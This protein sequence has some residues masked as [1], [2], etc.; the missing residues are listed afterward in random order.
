MKRR[1]EGVV[2]WIGMVL[3]IVGVVVMG[4]VIGMMGKGEVKE[5]LISEM[6]EEDSSLRYEEGNRIFRSFSG[7]LSSGLVLGIIV[8]MIAVIGVFLIRKK[9]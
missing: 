5:G 2:R 7:V 6:M 4:V 1:I 8:L 3:E 9:G